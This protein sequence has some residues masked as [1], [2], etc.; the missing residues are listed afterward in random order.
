MS[1]AGAAIITGAS[2]VVGSGLG[3][4][5]AKKRMKLQAGYNMEMAKYAYSKDLE[6]WNRKNVYNS[7]MQQMARFKEAGLNPMLMYGKGTAGAGQATELPKHSIP[8]KPAFSGL[9]SISKRLSPT[10]ELSKYMSLKSQQKQL[11]EQDLGIEEHQ[12]RND[13]FGSTMEW[14]LDKIFHEAGILDERGQIL[15]F[16]KREAYQIWKENLKRNQA[17]ST[18]AKTQ[19]DVEQQSLNNAIRAIEA[20][21]MKYTGAK[22]IAGAGIIGGALGLGRLMRF[23]G[24]AKA[25]KYGKYVHSKSRMSILKKLRGPGSTRLRY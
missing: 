9:E 25:L 24:R 18:L 6:M 13:L 23:G 2:N 17:R 15:S 16:Q 22:G 7:P 3:A 5:G 19:M 14:Q 10:D 4:I 8:Q 11:R 1:G 21:W 12:M 20:K